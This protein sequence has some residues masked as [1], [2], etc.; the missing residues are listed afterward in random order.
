MAE[1]AVDD[2]LSDREIDVLRSVALGR[3]NR[4]IAAELTI[5]ENTVKNHLKSI[6]SKLEADD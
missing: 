6:L 4:I 2:V 3:P 5:S 1:H